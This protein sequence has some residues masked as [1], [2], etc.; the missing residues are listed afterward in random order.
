[1]V[2]HVVL[3]KFKEGT[4]GDEI[5]QVIKA[6]ANLV[7]LIPT[8]GK[9]VSTENFHKRFLTRIFESTFERR[10]GVTRSHSAH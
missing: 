2:K 7:N 4:I 9:H 8:K 1:M 6:F 10:E 5:E 3:A